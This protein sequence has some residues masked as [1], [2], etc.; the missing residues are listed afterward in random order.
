MNS[1]IK[2]LS[3]DIFWSSDISFHKHSLFNV[4]ETIEMQNS[5]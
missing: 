1:Q 3:I 2:Q 5:L 4:A